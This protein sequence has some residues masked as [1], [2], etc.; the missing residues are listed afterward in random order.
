MKLNYLCTDMFFKLLH[1]KKKHTLVLNFSPI[2]HLELIETRINYCMRISM[3]LTYS[4]KAAK[5]KIGN[6]KK[7]QI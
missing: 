6:H 4:R 3:G 2:I 1:D 7:L 5:K